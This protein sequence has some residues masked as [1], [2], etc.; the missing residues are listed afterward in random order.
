MDEY[1]IYKYLRSHCLNRSYVGK[2]RV[3]LLV[4]RM[5]LDIL[6]NAKLIEPYE[7]AGIGDVFYAFCCEE[8][9]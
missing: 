4:G 8:E 9:S 6:V 2:T 1:E 5:G 3:Q 7:V